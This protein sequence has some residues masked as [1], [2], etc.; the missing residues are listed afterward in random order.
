MR[1]REFIKVLGAAAVWPRASH[2]QQVERMRRV[3]VLMSTGADD[4]EGQSRL[5]AFLQGLQEFNWA[6]GRNV[7]I[8]IRWTASNAENIRKHAAELVALAPD[9]IMVSGGARSRG[10]CYSRPAPYRSYSR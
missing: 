3:G 9:V 10:R 1:R 6:V 2:A 4:P 5:A 7:Q 8:D